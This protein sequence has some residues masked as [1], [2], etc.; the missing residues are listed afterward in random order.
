MNDTQASALTDK[1]IE[2]ADIEWQ[3]SGAPYSRLFE[4]IYFSREGGLEETHHVFLQ[5]N[6]LVRRWQEADKGGLALFTIAELGFGTGLNF[7]CCWR[8]WEQTA[9]QNL[10][11]HFIS[12]EKYPIKL[13]ALQQALSNWPQLKNFSDSLIEFYPDHSPGYHRLHL[14]SQNYLSSITLDLYYGD[15]QEMLS[16]QLIDS[17]KKY[18]RNRQTKRRWKVDAWFLDGFAPRVNPDMWSP[19]LLQ[20]ISALSG[21][22]TSLSSYSVAGLVVRG[23][24]A[25]GFTVEK[26]AGFGNK[27]QMLY[28][29]NA[30][31]PTVKTIASTCSTA[32]SSTVSKIDVIVIGAGL[33]G[34]STARQLAQR[35]YRVTV[36]EQ[37]A[38]IARHASGNPQ[39]VLQCRLN[40]SA[41]PEWNF[42]LQSYLYAS[43][44][45]TLLAQSGDIEWHNCG[46]LTLDSAYG[47]TRKKLN[48]KSYEHYSSRVLRRVS[49]LQSSALSGVEIADNG[50]F[51]PHG[52]W[53]NPV[54][55]CRMYLQHPLIS[56]H[57]NTK[58]ERLQY[59]GSTWHVYA[60]N[61]D[62]SA[63]A[64]N[65]VIANSYC[66]ANFD[67]SSMY[68]VMPLRGQVSYLKTTENSTQ[69]TC[70]VCAES[71]IVPA[72]GGRHSVGASYVKNST[73]TALSTQEHQQNI[74]GISGQ[75]T[76]LGLDDSAVLSGRASI[77]GS[78]R[79]H[80]PILGQLPDPNNWHGIYGGAQD[81][82][83]KSQAL[84]N[85]FFPGLYLNVGHGSHGLATTPLAAEYIACLIAGE[86]APLQKIVAAFIEPQRFIQR[87]QR[88]RISDLTAAQN[89]SG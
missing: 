19:A 33:A 37:D 80:M 46:V 54:A 4:D 64:A 68:P 24:A 70:V 72:D 12:C 42:N 67:Q 27:R 9:L 13:E 31:A 81:L 7:L 22:G 85:D 14:R 1:I 62:I 39:A 38:D 49:A 48:N 71:Y 43:R 76:S 35:G 18:Q 59:E 75:A 5:A 8:L 50:F 63:S 87:A 89:N 61:N 57:L 56:V 6:D 30:A 10:R 77:R 60:E 82:S 66:A 84:G 17:R 34:C 86:P 11:L 45:Y 23:L 55:L 79:D 25:Q 65:V 78:T 74:A 40:R 83:A 73:D 28:A 26:R 88:E 3:E 15:A 20:T 52:G 29:E 51:L 2:N 21:P 41:S 16:Q 32:K 44:L 36:L 47:N 53:L 58:A 69:L